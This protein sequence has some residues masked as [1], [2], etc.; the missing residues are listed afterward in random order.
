MNSNIYMG[1]NFDKYWKFDICKILI[2]CQILI[3][4]RTLCWQLRID[5]MNI[6][7]QMLRT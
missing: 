5:L 2:R 3:K 4:F 7:F 6:S 1:T